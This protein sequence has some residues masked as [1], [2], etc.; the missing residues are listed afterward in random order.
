MRQRKQIVKCAGCGKPIFWIRTKI[1][2]MMPCDPEEVIFRPGPGEGRYVTP[3]GDV[4]TGHTIGTTYISEQ[5]GQMGYV[6]HWAT[7]V[8]AREFKR[9]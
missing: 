8:K 6:P 4:A 2:K 7:C 1:G 3:D 9:L 5:G